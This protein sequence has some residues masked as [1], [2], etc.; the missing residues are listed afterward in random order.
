MLCLP[1][2]KLNNLKAQ[3]YSSHHISA[4]FIKSLESTVAIRGLGELQGIWMTLM[5]NIKHYIN[6]LIRPCHGSG[7]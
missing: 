7:G 4:V 3:E 5:T 2:L 1:V 6:F